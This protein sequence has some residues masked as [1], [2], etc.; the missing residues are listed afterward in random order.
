MS[1][2]KL[3][4]NST[5]NVIP[6]VSTAETVHLPRLFVSDQCIK[7]CGSLS[8]EAALATLEAAKDTTKQIDIVCH[9]ATRILKNC[10]AQQLFTGLHNQTFGAEIEGEEG[11]F[12]TNPARYQTF[13]TSFTVVSEISQAL[14]EGNTAHSISEL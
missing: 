1:E 4:S 2:S 9:G 12:L 7:K 3:N 6:A 11:Y 13:N 14:A 8:T 10:G 5:D